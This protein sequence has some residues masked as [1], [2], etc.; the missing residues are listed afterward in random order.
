[1]IIVPANTPHNVITARGA[2]IL[3]RNLN[4]PH[5]TTNCPPTN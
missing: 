5:P 3:I 2:P 4:V 1:M